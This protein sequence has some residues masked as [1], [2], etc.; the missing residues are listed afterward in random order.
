[1]QNAVTQD[2]IDIFSSDSAGVKE[3][4]SN[5]YYQNGVEVGYTA[6]G[7]WW[8][9]L[10]NKITSFL[11]A[12]KADRVSM[13]TELKNVLVSASIT[14]ASTEN[15]QLAK[16]VDTVCYN[17]T[18]AYDNEEITEVIDGVQVTHKINQ[19][20]VEGYTLYIPDTELL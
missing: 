9:W 4:P 18:E 16:A 13:L 20:Y 11:S 14:P 12:S 8:N 7:K 2:N 6:P 17:A 19:P 10:W 15:G 1:M 5:P 3:Q